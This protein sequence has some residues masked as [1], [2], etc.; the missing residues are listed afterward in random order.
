MID[1]SPDPRAGDT[2][3]VRVRRV[4]RASAR[5][6][7]ASPALRVAAIEAR[8]AAVHHDDRRRAAFRAQLST[9]REVRFR[10][11]IRLLR[12]RLEFGSF[13]FYQFLLM[14]VELLA[15]QQ[16]D[17][18]QVLLDD[19]TELGDDRRHE[20]STGLPITAARIENGLQLLNEERDV[21]ALSKHRRDDARQ[22]DDPLVVIEVFRV[23]EHLERPSLFVLGAFVEDDV[24]DR[25]VHRVVGDRR[26]DLV[27][28][29][30]QHLGTLHFF[31]E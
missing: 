13:L 31:G 5:R 9:L 22:R 15:T 8:H 18:L 2:K 10:K 20:L 3:T 1:E 7:K 14:L 21:T 6:R 25:D 19:M 4:A 24:V 28:G 16:T 27:R 23:D 30:D 17:G 11:G 29:A 12:T 26:F